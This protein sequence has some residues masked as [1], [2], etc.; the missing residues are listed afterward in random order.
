MKPVLWEVRLSPT[1]AAVWDAVRLAFALGSFVRLP[2]EVARVAGDLPPDRV[3]ELMLYAWADQVR[4]ALDDEVLTDAELDNLAQSVVA[5]QLL[6]RA[7]GI[8]S[9]ER[10]M[11]ARRG[12]A[13]PPKKKPT[14]RSR[15]RETDEG[16]VDP[17]SGS[18]FEVA[19]VGESHYQDALRDAAAGRP[20]PARCDVALVPED[21]NEY[22]A[23]AV[24]VDVRGDCVGYLSRSHAVLYRRR[25]SGRSISCKGLL[26]GGDAG[27][28][29]IGIW[30]DVEL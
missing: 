7:K 9:Y 25:Y 2:G 21:T 22:D 27:R 8:D 13:P 14:R 1:E 19:A 18:T 17:E 16:R 6:E 11:A 26:C 29:S 30:L 10:L 23:N 12:E 24:R 4:L 15:R 5:L 28:P 3:Q 20:S